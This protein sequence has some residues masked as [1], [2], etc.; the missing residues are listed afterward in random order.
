[1][2]HAAKDELVPALSEGCLGGNHVNDILYIAL[3]LGLFVVAALA[4]LG[5]E[6][7]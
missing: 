4:V 5:F 2:I 3:G 6:K 1:M 7:A